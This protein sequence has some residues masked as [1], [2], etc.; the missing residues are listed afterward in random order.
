[1]DVFVARQPIFDM[2][3]NTFGYELLFRNS[4]NNFFPDID[5]DAASS[6]VLSNSYFCIGLEKLTSGK[7]AFVNFTRDL[8][9]KQIPTLFS[10]IYLYSEILETIEPDVELISVI[11]QMS[12][13]G[14]NFALDDFV[15]HEK[16]EP[17]IP[18]ADI[19]KIDIRQTPLD[20]AKLLI[21][22]LEGQSIRYLA[23]KVET[24]EEYYHAIDAGFS[25][26][27]GYFF[28]KPEILKQKSIAPSQIHLLRIIGELNHEDT[29]IN[30]LE[31]IIKADVSVSYRLLQYMNS[32]YFNL[33]YKVTSIKGALVFLG[34]SEVRKI[35]SLL[36]MTK[37]VDSKPSELLRTSV[38][39]ARLC[40]IVGKAN[41][42]RGD[43]SELFLLGLFS[44]MDVILDT[45]IESIVNQLPISDQLKTALNSGEGELATY[46]ELVCDYEK[47]DWDEN[48]ISRKKLNDNNLSIDNYIEA[49]RWTD[50]FID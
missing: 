16:F 28:S 7:K 49:I 5:G 19:I 26:F 39:R 50:S 24:R 43:P 25:Y 48:L 22:K 41:G 14:C 4:L 11:S 3:L 31:N 44:L 8:L 34:F 37:L 2:K 30:R 33:P 42:Y 18:Y 23:E 36:V 29:D 10:P 21:D 45:E 17:F 13:K 46:L 40:E 15:F 35:V 9:L 1:M 6:T 47:G 20:E 38:I 32:A 27:Q 12:R